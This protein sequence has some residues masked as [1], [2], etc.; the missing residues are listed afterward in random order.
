M[1]GKIG[2]ARLQP[3]LLLMPVDGGV[4]SRPEV[5]TDDAVEIFWLQ[6]LVIVGQEKERVGLG[7]ARTHDAPHRPAIEGAPGAEL[8][9]EFGLHGDPGKLELL[10]QRWPEHRGARAKVH[11]HGELVLA[12][13]LDLGEI[14]TMYAVALREAELLRILGRLDVALGTDVHLAPVAIEAVDQGI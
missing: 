1:G 13:E 7:L 14:A 10:D 3:D 4:V 6:A 8:V 5:L 9:D 11:V 2:G 12:V